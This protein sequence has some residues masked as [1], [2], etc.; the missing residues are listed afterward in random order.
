MRSLGPQHSFVARGLDAL[1]DV[2][3]ARGRLDRAR[4]LYTPTLAIR[5]STLGATHPLVA[6]TLVNLAR[7]LADSGHPDAGL[8]EIRRAL[9]IYATAGAAGDDPDHFPR[10]LEVE[11]QLLAGRRQFTD[12]RARLEQS[13]ELRARIFGPSHPIVAGVRKELASV[14]FSRGASR[15]AMV[16]ALRTEDVGRLSLRNTIRFLPERQAVRYAARRPRGLNLALSVAA[17]S[18]GLDMRPLLDAVVQ[19]RWRDP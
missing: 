18:R 5:R 10:A 9:A 1:A 12:A 16:E 8:V 4:E 13:L 19:S 15:M 7:V 2:A 6:W 17:V 11:G 14:D 3:A